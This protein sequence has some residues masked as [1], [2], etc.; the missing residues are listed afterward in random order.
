MA[1]DFKDYYTTLGVTKHASAEEIK[2]AFRTLA[3]TCHPDLA[4]DADK[5]GAEARFKEINEAYEVLK[6]P[7]KRK[8]YDR[9]G[10]N[11]N[12][13]ADAEG[14]WDFASRPSGNAR[15]RGNTGSY[16]YHFG[17]TGFSDFFERFF[18]GLGGDPFGE[19]ASQGRG[20]RYRS[21]EAGRTAAR[22]QD[23]EAEIMVTLEEALN[24]ASRRISLSKQ[25]ADGRAEKVETLNVTIP[26]GVREGQRIRLAGQGQP[27]PVGGKPG[28][29]F[30]R[31]RFAQHPYFKVLES[32]IYFEL[33][34]APWEAVLGTSVQIP[35]LKGAA[36]LR[37]K[38]GAQSGQKLRLAG[39]GLPKADG[40]HGDFF[41]ELS[42]RVPDKI[43]TEEKELWESLQQRSNFNPRSN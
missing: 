15:T 38:P 35:T 24:G 32:D 19:V 40:S 9:L 20:H 21:G 6:D 13:Y 3:R 41:A 17:G 12:Q 36:K 11:W 43:S 1:V 28:D 27:S 8:K 42:I 22:G 4:K 5:A 23:V 18:G 7:E 31:V 29:L 14:S 26:A 34:L 2:K 25:T 16:E 30:L 33:K 39:H 37:V 10:S